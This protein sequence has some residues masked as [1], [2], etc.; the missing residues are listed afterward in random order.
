M[1]LRTYPRAMSLD[2]FATFHIA[3]LVL[4]AG[5][6]LHRRFKILQDFSLPDPS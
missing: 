1:P 2:T 4:A 3:I 6:C 5:S